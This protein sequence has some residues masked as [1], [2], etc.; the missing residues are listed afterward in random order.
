MDQFKRFELLVGKDKLDKI[1]NTNVLVLGIGGVGSYA[2]ESLIR[3]YYNSG[4]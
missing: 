1:K 3:R 4:F 2:V